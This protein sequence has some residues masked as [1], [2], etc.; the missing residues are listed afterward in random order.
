LDIG[1]FLGGAIFA[2]VFPLMRQIFGSLD[3]I[4]ISFRA[5]IAAPFFVAILA[6]ASDSAST[7]GFFVELTQW[8]DCIAVRTA[9][10]PHRCWF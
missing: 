10:E 4:S 1:D 6:N 5:I 8:L 7:T 3:R 9:F 2:V